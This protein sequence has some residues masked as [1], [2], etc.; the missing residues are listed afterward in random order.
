MVIV[1][2]EG[3]DYSCEHQAVENATKNFDKSTTRITVDSD[4]KYVTIERQGL[5]YLC[6][7]FFVAGM[8]FLTAVIKI[9]EELVK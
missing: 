1:E 6:A 3:G 2:N 9:A 5:Y 4:V 7:L 8:G